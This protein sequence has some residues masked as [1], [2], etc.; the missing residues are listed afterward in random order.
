MELKKVAQRQ[1]RF[2][3]RQRTISLMLHQSDD[4]GLL[5]KIHSSLCRFR[6]IGGEWSA[7]LIIIIYTDD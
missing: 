5:N 7:L 4:G 3:S 2:Y 6:I 1:K